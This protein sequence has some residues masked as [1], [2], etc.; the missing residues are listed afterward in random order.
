MLNIDL[1][2][3]GE[4]GFMFAESKHVREIVGKR[5]AITIGI[6]FKCCKRYCNT[7][8]HKISMLLLQRFLGDPLSPKRR[9]GEQQPPLSQFTDAGK[10]AS[11]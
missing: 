2:S 11:V 6:I 4:F 8:F 10:S 1:M 9:K 3:I 5:V 7:F